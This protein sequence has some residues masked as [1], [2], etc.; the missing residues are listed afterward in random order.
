MGNI[1]RN[2]FRNLSR[3][4][5]A[6]AAV[7]LIAVGGAALASPAHAAPT[8]SVCD[9]TIFIGVRGTGADVGTGVSED[10]YGW[11]SGGMG[12]QVA[13]LNSRWRGAGNTYGWKTTS[14]ALDYNAG[15]MTNQVLSYRG[16]ADKLA[17]MLNYYAQRCSP[18]LPGVFLAGHS[19]GAA[20]ITL[21]LAD[22]GGRG[23]SK[24]AQAMIRQVSLFGNP[25]FLAGNG[26]EWNA[27]S[28]VKT[29]MGLWSVPKGNR[30]S[31]T[32]A[33]QFN[34]GGR[35][36]DYCL[37]LDWVCQAG[38]TQKDSIHSGYAV[39]YGMTTKAAKYMVTAWNPVSSLS[40]TDRLAYDT[41][42]LAN[43]ANTRRYPIAGDALVLTS[44]MVEQLE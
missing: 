33:V 12:G 36:R 44:E 1:R 4:V 29:G 38:S 27:A 3:R 5:A 39:K 31:V 2:R 32:E 30:D 35:V 26:R 14:I 43:P 24:P 19:Q 18:Y 9:G 28:S 6:V 7:G 21:L 15:L 8:A 22:P 37:Q 23:L 20:V 13:D 11:T 34:F 42:V 41:S 16:A 40:K 25:Y 17:K 10:G